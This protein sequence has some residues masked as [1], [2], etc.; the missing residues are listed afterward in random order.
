MI[1]TAAWTLLSIRYPGTRTL[2][3]EALR[4]VHLPS[5]IPLPGGGSL[6]YSGLVFSGFALWTLYLIWNSLNRHRIMFCLALIWLLPVLSNAVLAG[7]QSLIPKGV[8]AV[9]LQHDKTQCKYEIRNARMSGS[10]TLDLT[11][12]SGESLTLRPTAQIFYGRAAGDH[13]PTEIEL[14]PIEITPRQSG[15]FEPR[16]DFKLSEESRPGNNFGSTANFSGNFLT[17]SLD[18]GTHKRTWTE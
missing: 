1:L 14:D 17:L 5:S 7:Y 10:C 6:I 13:V 4:L 18:D 16:F 15:L 2:Y 11:N 9:A 8:Y 3:E 12:R